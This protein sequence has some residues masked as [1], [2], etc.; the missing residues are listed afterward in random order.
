MTVYT[1]KDI[2]PNHD[3]A[4]TFCCIRAVGVRGIGGA[5]QVNTQ[6]PTTRIPLYMLSLPLSHWGRGRRIGVL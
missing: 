3:V 1:E 4:V 5:E 2:E 6:L